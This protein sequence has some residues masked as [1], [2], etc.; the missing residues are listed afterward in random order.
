MW[1]ENLN[2]VLIGRMQPRQGTKVAASGCGMVYTLTR[3]NDTSDDTVRK[4]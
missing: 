3:G 2:N 4:A 1:G